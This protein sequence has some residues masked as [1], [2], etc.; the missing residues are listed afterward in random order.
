MTS[1]VVDEVDC[2]C[3]CHA[4]RVGNERRSWLREQGKTRRHWLALFP[5][6]NQLTT[7]V[8]LLRKGEPSC[9][10]PVRNA[11]VRYGSGTSKFYALRSLA[12]AEAYFSHQVLGARL[13]E[14][15]EALQ[16]LPTN[17]SEAVLGSIDAAKLRSCLTLFLE[18]APTK[19]V[20]SPDRDALE[21]R[22]PRV[23][24]YRTELPQD[25]LKAEFNENSRL[26]LDPGLVGASE[27]KNS[28]IIGEA[29]DM[30]LD[31]LAGERMST[32][33]FK[34]TNHVM[35]R[36]LAEPGVPPPTHLFHPL[37]RIVRQWMDEYLICVG[38]TYPAQ[39]L[40]Q[41]IADMAGERTFC[42][43]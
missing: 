42:A 38:Q 27:T 6:W 24:G 35:N 34:L 23:E 4:C 20:I 19:Q 15:L 14:C 18:V 39:V 13:I 36:F 43:L 32:I 29:V 17:D 3:S 16:S 37:K 10:T 2:I 40:Y 31:H 12:E 8:V 33:L 30:T 7:V 25:V 9:P 41:V 21:I 1:F 26:Q 11:A 22:F 28:G 5:V